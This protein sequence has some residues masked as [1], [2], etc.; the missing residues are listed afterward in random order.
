M[1]RLII[2]VLLLFLQASLLATSSKATPSCESAGVEW[3]PRSFLEGL[4]E[5]KFQI[6]LNT[7]ILSRLKGYKAYFNIDRLLYS[8]GYAS[9]LALIENNPIEITLQK[10]GSNSP[11]KH[12]AYFMVSPKD[13]EK[14]ETICEGEYQIGVVGACKMDIGQQTSFPPNTDITVGL[15]GKAD[16]DYTL[17]WECINPGCL[18]TPFT[19]ALN[20][21]TDPN[22]RL[23]FPPVQLP[24]PHKSTGRFR[25]DISQVGP[26]NDS[27]LSQDITVDLGAP[28]QTAAPADLQPALPSQKCPELGEKFDPNKHWN[29]GNAGGQKIRR[30]T[31]DPKDITNYGIVTAIGCIHTNPATLVKD[32]L[33]F[34]VGI[35]G[36]L[37][38]LLMVVGA[39]QM[40][41]SQGNPDQLNA[42][43]ERLTNAVIG[44]LFVIFAVL[45][46]Q[47][48][49]VDILKIPGFER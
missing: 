7:N 34:V 17:K 27:C 2:F 19:N 6:T 8:G 23:T 24:Y 12:W 40:I 28:A 10:D 36:G 42:G 29:C 9:N 44:L 46:L 43:R 11:G 21:R 3:G 49:G 16:T 38:F 39:F 1:K 14:W 13:Q 5:Y 35:G 48:I 4:N 32:I 31:D 30:C 15:L 47:I 18:T 22:G 25:A 41:A 26:S 45:F 20:K 33:T 37:A